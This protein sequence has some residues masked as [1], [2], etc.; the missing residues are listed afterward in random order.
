MDG[1]DP[2]VVVL[3]RSKGRRILYGVIATM[4]VLAA[5]FGLSLPG[6]FE[7][8]SPVG[9]FFFL[10][11]LLASLGVALYDH[12]IVF[13]RANALVVE[14]SML[15]LLEVQRREWELASLKAIVLQTVNLMKAEHGT[16]HGRGG[17]LRRNARLYRLGIETSEHLKFVEDSSDEGELAH[18]GQGLAEFAGVDYRVDKM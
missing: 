5:A 10:I 16:T 12:R 9:V 7:D 18:I 2:D 13:D 17:L 14:S 3:H 4:L 15:A 8:I 1:R 6:A 11:L